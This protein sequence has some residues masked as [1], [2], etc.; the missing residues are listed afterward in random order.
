MATKVVAGPQH[1]AV[2][3]ALC[4]NGAEPP[5]DGWPLLVFLHGRG[6]AADR[7]ADPKEGAAVHGPLWRRREKGW[8]PPFLV[9]CP[10]LATADCRWH[11]ARNLLAVTRI[12][13]D[14]CRGPYRV[15]PSRILV[16]GFS[17]GGLGCYALAQT[18]AKSRAVSRPCALLPVDAYDE[19]PRWASRPDE[20]A[21]R[22][23]R[24]WSHHRTEN[25]GAPG[26]E[27]LIPSSER[28]K[29]KEYARPC[30]HPAA[31]RR[32]YG[33]TEWYRWLL[34]APWRPAQGNKKRRVQSARRLAKDS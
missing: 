19:P 30:S 33:D 29:S 22:G 27:K 12:I 28:E 6:E 11:E 18:W 5:E 34:N 1:G 23:L 10:Q 2:R 31:A 3:S 20:G 7:Y 17:I 32:T 16:T 15:N 24:V 14:V 4:E 26:L 21:I 13:A 9:V 25:G 8:E